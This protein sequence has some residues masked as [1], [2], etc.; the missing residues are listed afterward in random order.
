MPR[1]L[2]NHVNVMPVRGFVC[3][4]ASMLLV[5]R[6]CSRTKFASTNPQT[7]WKWTPM[8]IVRAWSF[9]FRESARAAVLSLCTRMGGKAILTC[10]KS[11]S[12]TRSHLAV[13]AVCDRAIYS[14][15]VVDVAMQPWS[16]LTHAMGA[17]AAMKTYA[18]VDFLPSTSLA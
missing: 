17:P 9:G 7:V 6:Y 16:L 10:P 3:P 8:C 2:R 5:G 15:S 12:S 1:W 14:A 13:L 18:P 11:A 4:S